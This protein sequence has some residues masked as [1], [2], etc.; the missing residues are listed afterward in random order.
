MARNE[1][2][3]HVLVRTNPKGEA[4]IGTCV[5]C[6]VAGLRMEQVNEFCENVRGLTQ[7]EAL[8]EV[9]DQPGKVYSIGADR[10]IE[11]PK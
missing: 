5:L 11:E 1:M 3:Q 10:W 4:F 2:T 8:L 6:G 9:I 7:E